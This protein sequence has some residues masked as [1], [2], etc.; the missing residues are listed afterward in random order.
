MKPARGLSLSL[1]AALL[2]IFS[3]LNADDLHLWFKNISIKEDLSQNSGNCIVQDKYGFMWFGTEDGLNRYDGHEFVV[4]KNNPAEPHSLADS[5][6][7]SL[8]EDSQ[9]ILWVG[10]YN[11]GLNRYDRENDKFISYTH[12]DSDPHSLSSNHVLCI[13]EGRKGFLW[14]GTQDGLNRFDPK[15]EF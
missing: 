8:F 12:K 14:I 13:C 11:G 9:G 5:Y 3:N 15:K 2:A 4:Y 7:L 6:I 10:T 1:M